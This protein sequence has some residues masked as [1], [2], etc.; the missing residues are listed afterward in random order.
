MRCLHDRN[1]EGNKYQTITNVS[2][3]SCIV[4]SRNIRH[5]VAK[6]KI[7]K[8][9]PQIITKRLVFQPSRPPMRPSIT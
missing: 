9:A 5:S 2:M 7:R 8:A 3:T 1:I 4:N 6:V